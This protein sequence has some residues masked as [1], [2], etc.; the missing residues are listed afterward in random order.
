MLTSR[1]P[2]DNVLLDIIEPARH[3]DAAAVRHAVT[4]VG[5]EDGQGDVASPDTPQK[6]V[7]C[8][9]PGDH[10]GPIGVEKLL[11]AFGVGTQAFAPAH[12]VAA[13]RP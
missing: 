2:Q 5:V 1:K 8:R 7:S 11:V 12:A 3:L 10:P 6:L 9:L 13:G 4:F